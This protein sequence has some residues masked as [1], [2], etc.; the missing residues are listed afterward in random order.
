MEERENRKGPGVF[1]AV[2][3]VATLVVAIIGATFAYFSV[4]VTNDAQNPIEGTTGQG[5]AGNLA[6]TVTKV[7]AG[8]GN[9]IPLAQNLMP[10]AL[11]AAQQCIDS[12]GNTVCQV[13]SIKIDNTGSSAYR[14][15]GKLVLTSDAPNMKWEKLSTQSAQESTPVVHGVGEA[16]SVAAG[17]VVTS[18]LLQATTGT[19]TYYVI[20]W[21]DETGKA[22]DD[23][24]K[25]DGATD[26]DDT[27]FTGT[28]TFN[29]V[30]ATGTAAGGLTATFSS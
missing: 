28:V 22:Q 21:L 2:I 15:A 8:S 1:Y 14:V 3:G 7:S 5:A 29:A 16:D 24:T 11:S 6:L 23:E 13:Y 27:S 20:V 18:E 10:N 19:A 17:S 30:D 26:E 4:T 9:L 25:T 12:N